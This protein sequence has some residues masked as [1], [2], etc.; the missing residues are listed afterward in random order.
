MSTPTQ[1]KLAKPA[2][3]ASN[4]AK[5]L[6]AQSAMPTGRP[7]SQ[8]VGNHSFA[9]SPNA[10]FPSPADPS[11]TG[12]FYFGKL[13]CRIFCREQPAIACLTLNSRSTE[14][15]TDN[16]AKFLVLASGLQQPELSIQ[17]IG[18][19]RFKRRPTDSLRDGCSS[20]R[21]PSMKLS[22]TARA[23]KRVHARTACVLS[24]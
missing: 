22:R 2:A 24:H 16:T 5:P 13:L 14:S 8:A 17:R 12:I 23:R 20:A 11:A 9:E 7:S 6:A 4:A 21:V 18:V 10:R 1:E 19:Q 15:C 3:A